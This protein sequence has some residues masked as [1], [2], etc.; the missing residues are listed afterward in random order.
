MLKVT[1]IL[2]IVF[3]ILHFTLKVTINNMTREEEVKSKLLNTYPTRIKVISCLWLLNL[4][5]TIV[6][7]IIT[8]IQW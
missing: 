4:I 6:C 8:I 7:L 5:A 3:V 2:A 1:L